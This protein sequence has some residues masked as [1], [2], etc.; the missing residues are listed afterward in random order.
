MV[1]KIYKNTNKNTNIYTNNINYIFLFIILL[2]I[3]VVL[4]IYYRKFRANIE[5][6]DDCKNCGPQI[7]DMQFGIGPATNTG[8]IK[9]PIPFLKTPIVFTQ[10]IGTPDTVA[11]GY[12]ITIYNIKNDGFDYSKHIIINKTGNGFSVTSM[13]NSTVEQFN[14]IAYKNDS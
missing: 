14:W 3:I 12:T 10:I 2:I 5:K 4:I 7:P 9:F 8:N 11:N 13:D 1:S 6:F